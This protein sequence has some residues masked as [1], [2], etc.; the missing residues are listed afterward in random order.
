MVAVGQRKRMKVQRFNAN[1]EPPL[2]TVRVLDR[3]QLP[4]CAW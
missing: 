4:R 3:R 1:D 2:M